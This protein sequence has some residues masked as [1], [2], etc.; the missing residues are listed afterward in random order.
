MALNL[1]TLHSPSSPSVFAP[2]KL[3]ILASSLNGCQPSCKPSIRDSLY[4]LF[5]PSLISVGHLATFNNS[6]RIVEESCHSQRFRF[7]QSASST[8]YPTELASGGEGGGDDANSN[9]NDNNDG[10]RGD[11]TDVNDSEKNRIEAILVLASLGKDISN[12]PADF[13][14]AVQDGRIP[15]CS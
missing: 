4:S 13:V 2:Q 12:V 14:S 9:D 5:E 1:T 7:S 10:S 8:L 15:D 6:T 3:S 11:G